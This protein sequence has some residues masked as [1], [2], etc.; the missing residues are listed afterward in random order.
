MK[1]D[2]IT[3]P[4]RILVVDDV[5]ANRQLLYRC[6]TNLGHV[7]TMAC[8][9]LEALEACRQELPDLIL[10][11]I[12]MP[13]MDGCAA[14]TAIRR[15]CGEQWLPIIFLSAK[16][17]EA[18]QIEGLEIGD[19]YLTK[20]VNLAMLKAKIKV[21][22]RIADMQR[23]IA[24][25]ASRL[26][27]YRQNNE[28]DQQFSR[29]ILDHI[30]GHSNS[31]NGPVKRWIVPARHLS[32][33]VI[34]YSHSAAGTI[35]LL[36]ADSTGHGLAAAISAVPAV[37]T[38]YAMTR[39]GHGIGA[40]A[41]EINAKLH[42][43][44]PVSRFVAAALVSI[45]PFRERIDV[46][47]A[48]IPEV[49]YVTGSGEIARRWSSRHPPLGILDDSAFDP[50]VETWQ[51]NEEGEIFVCSDGV[52]EAE[53][54]SGERFGS[55]RL[56]QAILESH[57][58]PPF[59]SVIAAV[60]N[61]L[62]QQDNHDDLSLASV[63]CTSSLYLPA[64]ASDKHSVD[65][66]QLLTDLWA[67]RLQF[68]VDEIRRQN[69]LPAITRWLNQAGL[70]PAQ[71]A[72][73]LLIVTELCNNGIDH[74]VLKLDSVLKQG[75]DGFELYHQQRQA[76]LAALAAGSIEVRLERQRDAA[77]PLLRLVV[78]DSGSGFAHEQ[79]NA[80][81]GIG[82][83]LPHG[84]GIALVRQLAH[85]LQYQSGGTEAIVDFRLQAEQEAA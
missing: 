31:R 29:Y 50:A 33:D 66:P 77:G 69:V 5:E 71:F 81:A 14:A 55:E 60:Y 64:S 16:S 84:R 74:G 85:R 9:G 37:D 57:G 13:V 17:S 43:L 12:M 26:E 72:Q 82:R 36:I 15:L 48:G 4:L 42:Q 83:P 2:P 62:G 35:N 1:S 10:M 41:R 22:A 34:A 59:E 3:S 79:L 73:L 45:D 20:P 47:N 56:R 76:R 6:I 23:R 52:I 19:D 38:F 44:L 40:I 24:E 28:Q 51:W 75:P 30:I 39:R 7:T 54:A 58:K 27:V 46:W 25:N 61:H 65:T 80:A 49:M 70:D 63:A 68:S 53:S 32:G 8:N 18:E 21:M 78:K 67:L 11:D